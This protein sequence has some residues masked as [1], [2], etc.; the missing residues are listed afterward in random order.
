MPDRPT[1]RS[2][3]RIED[4][5]RLAR[6]SNATVSRALSQPSLLRA[7]TLAR[8]EAA[9]AQLAYVPHAAARTLA[10]NRSRMIGALLPTLEHTSFALTAQGLQTALADRGYTLV[11]ACHG[12]D[13]AAEERLARELVAR[14]VDGL[15]FVGQQRSRELS[16]LLRRTQTPF[17]VGW[18]A[19]VPR[20]TWSVGFDNRA[21]SALVVDHLVGLGH[22]R[23]ALV[24][25]LRA[26]NDRAR[27]RAEG[28]VARL[29]A[30]G[31][32]IR[33]AWLRECP[34][35][36]EAGAAAAATILAGRAGPTALV[37]GNDAIAVGMLKYAREA[38]LVV[39]RDLSIAGFDDQ[40]IAGL[41]T[42]GLT[43]VR[44]PA[45]AI[46]ERAAA[47]LVARIEARAHPRQVVLEIELVVRESTGPAPRRAPA[48]R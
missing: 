36:I 14:G 27:A 44:F 12:Y 47:A 34:Y 22:R 37:G 9:V 45:Q 2:A 28:V 5:A 39:P 32:A 18:N 21:A 19:D 26:T 23:V 20:G 7:D 8:V 33:P 16:A 25:G 3:P 6:V 1:A 31:I 41:V 46:G 38:G 4:V 17:V 43:T 24:A 11:L 13:L 15:F 40:E 10:S 29:A 35:S 48:G 42:P 30:H